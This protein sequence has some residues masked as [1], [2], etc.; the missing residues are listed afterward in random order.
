MGTGFSYSTDIR[1][2]RHDEKGVGEDMYDFFQV[3]DSPF[4]VQNVQAIFY[5][6]EVILRSVLPNLSI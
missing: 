2:I 3:Q 1:D 5:A 4:S 6:I